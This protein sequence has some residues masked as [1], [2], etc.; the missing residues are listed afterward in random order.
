VPDQHLSDIVAWGSATDDQ[1]AAFFGPDLMNEL[2]ARWRGPDTTRYLF[3]EWFH[4]V[5][6]PIGIPRDDAF[7]LFTGQTTIEDFTLSLDETL[8]DVF[9]TKF[10]ELQQRHQDRIDRGEVL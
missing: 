1:L 9:L 8:L 7:A 3:N 5:M 6:Q 10:P 4:D 2:A